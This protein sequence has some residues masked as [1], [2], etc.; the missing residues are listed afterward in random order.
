M[1]N[2]WYA[3]AQM[4]TPN[5]NAMA[6]MSAQPHGMLE[7]NAITKEHKKIGIKPHSK[8]NQKKSSNPKISAGLKMKN[9]IT[10]ARLFD[11]DIHSLG[12]RVMVAYSVLAMAII[13]ITNIPQ[14]RIFARE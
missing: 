3:V 10:S 2:P 6:K 7:W 9:L 4:A 11:N 1:L 13:H 14:T 8:P 5:T 12:K